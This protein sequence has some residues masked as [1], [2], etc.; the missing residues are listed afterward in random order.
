MVFVSVS[1]KYSLKQCNIQSRVAFPLG[2]INSPSVNQY[3]TPLSRVIQNQKIV[4]LSD[5]IKQIF[6]EFNENKATWMKEK[7][8]GGRGRFILK[9][10]VKNIP[11]I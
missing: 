10:S 9:C 11:W 2:A 3:L 8:F 7:F 1:C 6:N 4:R 5:I